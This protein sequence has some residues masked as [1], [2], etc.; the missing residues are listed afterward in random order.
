MVLLAVGVLLATRLHAGSDYG[1]LVGFTVVAASTVVDDF[2]GADFDQSV[3]LDNGMKFEFTEF[4]Y[5]YSFRPSVAVLARRFSV[6]E[7]RKMGIQEPRG[8]ITLYKLL[9]DGEVYDVMRL[10]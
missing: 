4:S 9:I 1:E 6:E 3:E 10:R 7:Q 2:E 8:P 5:T